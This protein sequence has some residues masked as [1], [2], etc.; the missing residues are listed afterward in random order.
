MYG[1]APITAGL[2]RAVCSTARQSGSAPLF[3]N[4]STCDTTDSMRSRTWYTKPFITDRTT[5][6]AITPSAMPIIEIP[7]MNEMNPLRRRARLPARV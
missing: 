5:I 6:S 7:E 1:A 3:A 4:T 2:R